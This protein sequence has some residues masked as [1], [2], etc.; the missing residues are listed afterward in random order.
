MKIHYD[1][2]TKWLDNEL[3]TEAHDHPTPA[4]SRYDVLLQV[5]KK[6]EETIAEQ[7]ALW[8]ASQ[9]PQI[10]EEDK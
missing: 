10:S 8:L 3:Y 4:R 2:F 9:G 7:H 1:A 6:L 5:K